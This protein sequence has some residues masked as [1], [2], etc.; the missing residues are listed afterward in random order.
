MERF[1][2]VHAK[3]RVGQIV[4]AYAWK[5]PDANSR[6]VHPHQFINSFPVGTLCFAQP[7]D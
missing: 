7:V 2:F 3:F 1:L 4:Y 5:N 6:P